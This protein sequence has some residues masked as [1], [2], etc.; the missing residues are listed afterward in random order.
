[1]TKEEAF[2][3]IHKNLD[4]IQGFGV[5]RIGLFGST[6]EG[7]AS[8]DSDIDILV[9]FQKGHKSFDNFMDLKFLLEGLF[10]GRRIDLLTMDSLH[11]KLK[12]TV[13]ASAQ[14]VS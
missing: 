6:M 3:I 9:E 8:E 11:P 2:Q 7:L 5:A 12:P 14:Y 13:L 4:A 10:S 1:M